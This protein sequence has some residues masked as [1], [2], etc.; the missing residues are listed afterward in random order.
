MPKRAWAASRVAAEARPDCSTRRDFL[1]GATTAATSVVAARAASDDRAG[2]LPT[3]ALGGSRVTRLIAGGNP[4]YGYSHFNE[5]YSRHMLEW[6][7]DERVV[8]SSSTARKRGR[9]RRRT[10]QP[11]RVTRPT[12]LAAQPR[13]LGSPRDPVKAEEHPSANTRGYCRVLPAKP[14]Q[15]EA[16]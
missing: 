5:Q 11:R 2:L 10:V 16:A 6:F 15:E 1:I 8:Q 14:R 3:V 13:R 4:L 7:T 12:P 9:P